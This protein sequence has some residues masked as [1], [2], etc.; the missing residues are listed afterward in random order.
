MSAD[1]DEKAIRSEDYKE[2]P[3]L[4][5][6]AK[7]TALLPKIEGDAILITLDEVVVWKNELREKPETIEQAR[8]FL[9]SYSE[10]PAQTY[11]S[12]VVHNTTTHAQYEG[13]DIARVYFK[14][15]P[16]SVIQQLI[17]EG[18]IM[19]AAGGFIIEDPLLLPYI[20]RIEGTKESVMGLPLKL[21]D[22][23][24]KKAQGL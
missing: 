4:L 20:D 18:N 21:T 23:L 1:I 16:D 8:Y 10:S 12:I 5:A 2:L 17:D 11:T 24:I 14:P 19:W 22:E 7:C 6:R 3:L 15:I 9:T 13:L